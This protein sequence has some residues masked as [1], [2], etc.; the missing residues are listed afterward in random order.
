MRNLIPQGNFEA[1]QETLYLEDGAFVT[2]P[3][4]VFAGV[5]SCRLDKAGFPIDGLRGFVVT[6]QLVV[7]RGAV[8]QVSVQVEGSTRGDIQLWCNYD[9]GDGFGLSTQLGT[10][11]APPGWTLWEP[12]TFIAATEIIQV[13]LRVISS[14]TPIASIYLDNWV[15]MDRA[16]RLYP[17]GTFTFQEAYTDE[18]TGLV[19]RRGEMVR[20]I[21]GLLRL[22]DDED[23]LSRDELTRMLRDSPQRRGDEP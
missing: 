17:K 1:S 16:T 20:D 21:D 3:S 15:V 8:V 23:D 18:I 9:R 4:P 22:S 19:G 13:E 12:G 11:L 14:T 5:Y 2:A 7:D 10:Y 6:P